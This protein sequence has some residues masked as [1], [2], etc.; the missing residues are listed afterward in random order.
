[1]Y[2]LI[3][4]LFI[5]L[6]LSTE[7]FAKPRCDTAHLNIC[8]RELLQGLMENKELNAHWDNGNYIT[9]NLVLDNHSN[10]YQ[11]SFSSVKTWQG[12]DWNAN[13]VFFLGNNGY[14]ILGATQSMISHVGSYYFAGSWHTIGAPIAVPPTPIMNIPTPKPVVVTPQAVPNQVP[15][16]IPQAN[17]VVTAPPLVPTLAPNKVPQPKPMVA[18]QATPPKIT[19]KTPTVISHV[20]GI[21]NKHSKIILNNTHKKVAINYNQNHKHSV[22]KQQKSTHQQKIIPSQTVSLK[23][24]KLH[25]KGPQTIDASNVNQHLISSVPGDNVAQDHHAILVDHND[26]VWRCKLS[27]LGY[28]DMKYKGEES[29][30]TGHAETMHFK[31]SIFSHISNSISINNN[32]LIS[33]SK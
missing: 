17:K 12:W 1:M 28:R 15:H 3:T 33:V 7:S 26:R 22:S 14:Q 30:P 31:N 9:G 23:I 21:G 29:I 13:N 32:C 6:L 19:Q 20:K 16:M 10:W 2:K 18:P 27:G 11:G 24:A 4:F 8:T 25:Y 5:I